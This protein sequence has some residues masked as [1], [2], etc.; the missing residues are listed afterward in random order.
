MH[1]N[2]IPYLSLLR[3]EYL[4]GPYLELTCKLFNHGSVVFSIITC[5]MPNLHTDK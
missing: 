1:T 4:A 2:Y 3:I 5:Y